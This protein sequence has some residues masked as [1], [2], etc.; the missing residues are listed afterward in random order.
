M[1]TTSLTSARIC[2]KCQ[3][4][5]VKRS[6]RTGLM[7]H[8]MSSFSI[9]PFRCQLCSYRFYLKQEGARYKRIADDRR[10]YDRLPVNL[11]ATF[12]SEAF[13]GSGAVREISMAGCSLRTDTQLAVGN[14]LRI[15]L[16]LP[17]QAEPVGIEIAIIRSVQSHH[18]RLEF[19]EFKPGDEDRLQLFV[20]GLIFNQ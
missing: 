15:D 18:A 5:F 10:D 13:H 9:Y 2:P 6:R 19:L 12:R 14:I 17:V 8:L 1:F 3:T 11:A 7:N 16:Q 20:A 4:D